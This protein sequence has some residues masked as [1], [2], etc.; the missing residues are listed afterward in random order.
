[1][2]RLH[3]SRRR[4]HVRIAHHE[5]ARREPLQR[6]LELRAAAILRPARSRQPLARPH[7]AQRLEITTHVELETELRSAEQDF[8]QG[9]FVEL[10][11]QELDGCVKANEWPWA[12]TRSR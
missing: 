1:M 2:P 7:A 12:T 10:T 11:V 5:P 6:R 9:D 4:L 3:Q 8:A